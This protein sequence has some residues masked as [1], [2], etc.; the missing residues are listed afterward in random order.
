[1]CNPPERAVR[2][3]R[4]LSAKLDK[5]EKNALTRIHH[6]GVFKFGIK[7]ADKYFDTFFQYV[8]LIAEH[9]FSFETVNYIKIGYR[10]CICGSVGIFYRIEDGIVGIMANIVRQ[11]IDEYL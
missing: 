3:G 8:D 9:P 6:Y 2:Y 5:A 4:E 11:N 1:M 10:R 7:Q